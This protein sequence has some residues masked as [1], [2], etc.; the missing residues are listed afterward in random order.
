MNKLKR[1][2]VMICILFVFSAF[3]G[4][5]EKTLS[6]NE[7]KINIEVI[8]KKKDASFWT[9]VA[10]GCEAAG[11]E[12]GANVKIDGPYDENNIDEQIKMVD[13]A[14]NNKVDAI[15]LAAG[16]YTKL[17]NVTEKA[18]MQKIPVIIIDSELNSAK[19]KAFVGTDNVDAGYKL[20]QT[21]ADK[22]GSKCRV[23]VMNFIKGAAT[24]DQREQGVYQALE[25]YPEI[26][27]ISKLYCNSD[28]D[29]AY[30]LTKNILKEY[31]D[32]NAIVCTN[33]YG[34][35]GT[36]RAI[37]DENKAGKVKVIGFDSTPEEIGF[38]EK[39][40]IEALI[41]QN[42]FNMGY[43]GV[44]YALDSVKKQTVPK[45]TNTGSVIIDKENMYL[46]ENEKLVFPF[47]N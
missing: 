34:T 15:V 2:I 39:G 40:V 46:P 23:A 12:F 11:K 21:L 17:V 6:P 14:V 42:P 3:P 35:T 44:K 24:S 27:V 18:V 5:S 13:D 8:V 26:S 1:S 32:L 9:V 10:M 25:L 4:C 38:V 22:V 31:P 33:A 29:T 37:A 28:E 20:G 45:A 7:E 41:V 36:A 30:Q 16:D 43:L 47:T 19:T